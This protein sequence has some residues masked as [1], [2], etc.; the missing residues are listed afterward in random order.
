MMYEGNIYYNSNHLGVEVKIAS[1]SQSQNVKEN[2]YGRFVYFI[3]HA[4]FCA[5]YIKKGV[6]WV[7]SVY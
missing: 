6:I 5:I 1:L 3:N 7:I 4:L 2:M